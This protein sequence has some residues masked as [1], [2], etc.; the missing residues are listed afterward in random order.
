ML[1]DNQLLPPATLGNSDVTLQHLHWLAIIGNGMVSEFD[2]SA[3]E[4][5]AFSEDDVKADLYIAPSLT[6]R[7]KDSAAKFEV[8]DVPRT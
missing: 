2:L 1:H 5:D 3:E 8:D 7:M 6:Q 4:L